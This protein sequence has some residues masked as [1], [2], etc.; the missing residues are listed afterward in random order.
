MAVMELAFATAS[1][2]AAAV[3]EGRIGATAVAEAAFSRI[4]QHNA[5]LNAFTAPLLAR[6]SEQLRIAIAR[7]YFQTGADP[8]ALDAVARVA[9]ALNVDQEIEIPEAARARAAAFVITAS[10]G[11][12]LHLDRLRA[13][14]GDFDPAVR[15]RL[16]AGA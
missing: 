2:I 11:A 9:A 7:G 10:E 13:R 6:G 12:T 5:A 3:S 15:D 14:A 1:E 16:I 8:R 4:A